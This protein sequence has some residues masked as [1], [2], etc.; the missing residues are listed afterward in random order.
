MHAPLRALLCALPLLAY[1]ASSPTPAFAY[2]DA[3]YLE[4][5]DRMTERLDRTWNDERGIYVPGSGGVDALVNAGLLLTHSVAAQAGHH[6]PARNDQRARRIARA[7]VSSPVFIDRRPTHVP[8]GSQLH[9][10]GWGSS[11]DSSDVGQHLVFDAGIVDGL[12]H[13]WKAR[14]ALDLPADTARMIEDRIHRVANSGFYRWPTIRLN[15]VNWYALIYA[16]DA[17]VTGR[18]ALLRRDLRAQLA[19]FVSGSRNFGPGLRFQYI[20]HAPPS[21]RSNIDSAEY[22]NIV[23]S[24]LR[25]YNQGRRAGMAPLPRAGRGLIR[26]WVRR[27]IAGYWTHGGYLNWDSG[28]GFE[29]WH[30]AKKLGLSQEALIG[31]AQTPRLQPGREWG[32][33]AKWMLDRGLRFYEHLPVKEGG[34]PDPVL[35]NLFSNP[36]TLGSARLAATRLAA[37]AARAFEAGLGRMRGERPPALYAFDPDIGRLAITTPAYNTAIIAVN[38]RAFPYGGI[39]LA[40]LFDGDQEVAAGIGGHAPAAFGLLVREPSGK[41]VF[42]SQTG[43]ARVDPGVTPVRLTR[44]PS[45]TG[46]SVRTRPGK[47]FAGPFRDLRARG[48]YTAGRFRAVTSH[49]FTPTSIETRW[50]L[51]RLRGVARLQALALLPSWGRRTAR[52]VAVL[53]NGSRVSLRSHSVALARVRHF[54]VISRRSGYTVV[55]LRRPPGAVARVMVPSRQSSAPDPGPTLAVELAHGA[56]WRRASFAVRIVVTRR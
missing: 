13:A 17:T 25:F 34:L 45:G 22:A 39:E 41:R 30:Q 33:W 38:Q 53:R 1:A 54:E 47:V 9:V 44:A 23:I 26:R 6:G 10:P 35:F 56:S 19:R 51:T 12:V 27:V 28:L 40:R 16:A 2:D 20:P 50:T 21:I 5:A 55:P 43:R 46:A 24:F 11:M 14:R 3:G 4:Y 48:T 7:L 8:P 18:S 29:R 31:I 52:V 15:Q 37:N 36:Q 42:S 49:R 32:R